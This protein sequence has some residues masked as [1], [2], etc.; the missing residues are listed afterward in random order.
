MS[1]STLRVSFKAK[2][3]SKKNIKAE[4]F[5]QFFLKCHNHVTYWRQL[6]WGL[7]YA[8]DHN[9]VREGSPLE[10]FAAA[11]VCGGDYREA[12]LLGFAKE[13]QLKFHCKGCA[14]LNDSKYKVYCATCTDKW[15]AAAEEKAEASIR[16]FCALKFAALADDSSSEEE[17][18]ES[19]NVCLSP[20]GS[21]E[22][23]ETGRISPP[24]VHK[25][26]LLRRRP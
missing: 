20:S 23:T 15:K 9:R 17:E 22:G 3:K 25:G 16:S 13:Y 19:D 6:R 2:R 18:G 8:E 14:N 4:Q 7:K 5:V 1:C 10:V 11:E 12:T 26:P 24:I 21:V